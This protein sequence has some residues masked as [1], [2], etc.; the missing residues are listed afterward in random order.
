M[1]AGR[2]PESS[3][4]VRWLVVAG[5]I[6]LV[7]PGR[8]VWYSPSVTSLLKNVYLKFDWSIGFKEFHFN[9]LRNAP[10]QYLV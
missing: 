10:S 9:C 8:E 7:D 4:G 6:Y 3:V 1:G 5:R 2:W